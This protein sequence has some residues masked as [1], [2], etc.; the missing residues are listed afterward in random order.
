MQ[1]VKTMKEAG[2]TVLINSG[3]MTDSNIYVGGIPDPGGF[4]SSSGAISDPDQAFTASSASDYRILLSHTPKDFPAT[5][6]DL[7]IA[8]HTHGGQIMPF[9]FLAKIYNT[10]LAG[11]YKITDEKSIYVSRGAGQWGPQMRFMA[12]SEIS[13]LLFKPEN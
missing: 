4:R 13:E 9:H 6:F 3:I 11:L 1:Y 10:Y 2:F 8:G 5:S 7:E 12:P